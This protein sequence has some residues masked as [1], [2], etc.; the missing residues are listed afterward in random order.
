MFPAEGKGEGSAI[1]GGEAID[2]GLEEKPDCPRVIEVV[3]GIDE[4]VR[5]GP[6]DGE[7]MLMT[8]VFVSK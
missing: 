2:G 3:G 1:P 8:E 7:E 5:E 4:D 6:I